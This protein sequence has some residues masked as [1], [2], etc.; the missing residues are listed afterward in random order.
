MLK[1]VHIINGVSNT[2]LKE[3]GVILEAKFHAGNIE[4]FSPSKVQTVGAPNII[5]QFTPQ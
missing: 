4:I 2:K 1:C 3:S 5:L